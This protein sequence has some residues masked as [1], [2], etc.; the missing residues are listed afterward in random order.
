MALAKKYVEARKKI[1]REKRYE[2]DEALDLLPQVAYAKFD[3][4]V[5]L[6][7]RLGVDPRHADQMVRGSVAL[8][9]GLGKSVRVLVFAKG[10]KEKE[11]QESGADV[12]GAEDL[13]E[14]IQKG[15]MEFDKAIATPDVMGM[16]SKLGKI[17]GPRGLMPNPKVGTVTFDI[18]KTVKEMKAGRVEFRVDKA[19]NLHV[20]VGKISFGK[21]KLL[22]NLN[23]LLDA[24][25]RLKPPTS[26]GT[27]VKGMAIS[28]TMS[29]GIKIDPSYARNLTK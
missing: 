15:W 29:P 20:P 10:E 3:E 4:T 17:L 7:L 11:A 2:L 19:G 26:K 1:D 12:V 14:K 9:N 8:P 28:T 23:S 22:E 16:V 27:Y 6:A 25:T 18:A 13:I 5:E 21:E 24:V